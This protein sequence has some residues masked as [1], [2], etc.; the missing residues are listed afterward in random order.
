M[1]PISK[2]IIACWVV[3]WLYWLISAFGSKKNTVSNIRQFAGIRLG[4]FVLAIILFRF[5]N[6]QN[7]PFQN[8]VATSNELVLAG[9]FIIFLLGIFLAIWARLYLGKNWGMP[10]TQKQDPE[11][12]TSGPYQYIRHPIYSGILLAALGSALA[13]SIF[14]LTIFAIMGIYFIYSAVAEERLMTK[15]FPKVYPMYKSKTKM[16]IPFV[17]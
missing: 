1:S 5:L 2:V 10:M 8:S 7:Y 16:L 4:I 14:W 12:V 3:F 6:V 13:S 11:L 17:F 9:G 15:Q